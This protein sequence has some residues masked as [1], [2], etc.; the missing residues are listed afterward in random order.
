MKSKIK[1][2]CLVA[3]LALLIVICFTSTVF[4]DDIA[5]GTCGAYDD[6]LTWVLNVDGVLTISGTGDMASYSDGTSPWHTKRTS[7]TNIVIGKGVTSIGRYAFANC[8]KAKSIVIPEGVTSIGQSAFYGCSSLTSVTIP[9]GVT[10][11][12]LS[13]FEGCI[14]LASI[15][16]PE[17]M[18]QI[19]Y[20]AFK[21]CTN[22]KKVYFTSLSNYLDIQYG[23]IYGRPSCYG[24][25]LYINGDIVTEL[26]IPETMTNIGDY[27]FYGCSS[28]TNVIIPESVTSIGLEAFYGCDSLISLNI[29]KGVTS[30]K[31]YTFYNC[32][33]LISI[34]IPDNVTSIGGYA[35]YGC[36]SLTSI[37]I[38]EGVIDIGGNAFRGCSGLESVTIPESVTCISGS[39]FYECSSLTSITIPEGVTTIEYS[40][41]YGC[42][43]LTSIMIPESVTNIGYEAFYNCG[44]LETVLILSENAVIGD[45]AFGS[46]D[47]YNEVIIFVVKDSATETNVSKIGYSSKIQ[48]IVKENEHYFYEARIKSPTCTETGVLQ[49]KC[50]ICGEV[51]GEPTVIPEL[52]HLLDGSPFSVPRT[53]TEDG[54]YGIACIRCGE[55]VITDTYSALGHNWKFDSTTEE[56]AKNGKGTYIS[57]CSNCGE[58]REESIYIGK[59]ADVSVIEGVMPFIKTDKDFDDSTYK[60]I[61]LRQ[62]KVTKNSITIK[63]TK[64]DSGARRFLVYAAKSGKNNRFQKVSKTAGRMYTLKKL[65]KKALNKGTYY[66]FLVVALDRNNKVLS[67]SKV[68]HIATLGRNAASNPT[69]VTTKAKKDKVTVKVKKTFKL[70]G[71]YAS[72]AKK[73][74][75]KKI[76]GMRYESTNTKVATVSSTGVIKGVKKGTC[77]VYA[78]AQNGIYKRIKV[79]V[80]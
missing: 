52:G 55:K 46:L 68:I 42:S 25:D 7:I 14:S 15:S 2:F 72:L 5:S 9:D 43:S 17:S 18:T 32:S 13:A 38:P 76:L 35:F 16:I 28:L 41:F 67:Y 60:K 77:Y 64:G 73:Y 8:Y 10:N 59:D 39:A 49:Q 50:A 37:M 70:A 33:S 45:Y 58:K 57:S 63:W 53:C 80:K 40:A 1:V 44:S 6:N 61:M 71:T 47:G 11:I 23:G 4:A 12:E 24:A 19:N 66:K 22:L 21:S 74:K 78:Y 54:Y 56:A 75:I 27:A 34:E 51:K 30:I 36:S 3:T 79:T 65:N 29:P 31:E 26:T 48:Y 69:E 62:S 20:D